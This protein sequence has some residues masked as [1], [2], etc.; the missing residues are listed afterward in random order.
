M[1][2]FDAK[3]P[4]TLSLT[5]YKDRKKYKII[6]RESI[7]KECKRI[8]DYFEIEIKSVWLK[9]IFML[10]ELMITLFLSQIYIYIERKIKGVKR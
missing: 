2:C 6:C 8:A 3:C 9:I 5:P 1:V 4:L 7:Y 10:V